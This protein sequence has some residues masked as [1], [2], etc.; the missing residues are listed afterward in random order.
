MSSTSIVPQAID[1]LLDIVNEAMTG[2]LGDVTAFEV[3]PGTDA[4]PKMLVLGEVTWDEYAIKT[5]KAGRQHRDEDFAVEFEVFVFDEDCTPQ[6]PKP[7]RDKGFAIL[8]AVEDALADDPH[9]ALAADVVRWVEIRP[10]TSG[11]R[12]FEGAYAH[13]IA[14]AFIGHAR[15]T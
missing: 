4:E 14:G 3:W 15:L 12:L 2:E 8:A 5:I 1:S 13:R 6:N 9:A 7:A 11:L 10:R